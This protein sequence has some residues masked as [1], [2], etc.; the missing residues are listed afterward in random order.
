LQLFFLNNRR[1]DFNDRNFRKALTYAFDFDWM[2]KY[3]F[4][5]TYKR[6]NSYFENSIFQS[7]STPNDEE[8]KVL[9]E[10]EHQL[11]SEV[12]NEEFIMPKTDADPLKNRNN[13]KIAKV[14]LLEAGY[15]IKNNKLISPYTKLPVSIEIIYTM[16]GFSRILNT[17]K[18]NLARLGIDV[19]V[20]LVDSSQYQQRLQSFD[21]DIITTAF[22]SAPVV[23]D[24]HYR[25]WHS[26]S[27]IEGGYNFAGVHDKVIDAL[28]GK[29]IKTDNVDK[30]ITFIKC[31]DRV[32]LWNYYTIPQMYS[33][34]Y[35]LLYWNKFNIPKVRPDY[36][37]GFDT[38][39]MKS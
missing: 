26:N 18:L 3:L 24:L 32:L 33:H 12:F 6:I 8:L 19:R 36:D 14:E 35:R 20:R 25:L 22:V 37:Q 7:N 17:Y 15:T 10:F 31:L 28:L 39:W 16:Q 9:K 1:P 21:F 30:Q 27:D 34:H 29:I 4:Y 11:P 38:W 13:L 2:N 5:S 23:T